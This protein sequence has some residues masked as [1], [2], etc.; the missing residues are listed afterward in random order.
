MSHTL[1]FLVDR[2]TVTNIPDRLPRAMLTCVHLSGG[3]AFGRGTPG[4]LYPEPVVA[5]GFTGGRV[6]R[7]PPT[8]VP[9][10]RRVAGVQK[11]HAKSGAN[12]NDSPPW[13]AGTL[14]GAFSM[15]RVDI[16][17]F[18]DPAKSMCG[19]CEASETQL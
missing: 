9:R 7:V 6:G 2:N 16:I 1:T 18:V 11:H 4:E 10:I 19:W 3:V 13:Q 5:G 15:F 14:H 17:S 8:N 12:K